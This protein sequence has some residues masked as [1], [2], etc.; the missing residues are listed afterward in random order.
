MKIDFQHRQSAHCENGVTANLLSFYGIHLSEPMIFGIGSGYFFS[1]MPFIKLHGMPV[2]SFRVLPGW[3]FKRVTRRLGIQV[4]RYKFSDPDNAMKELNRLL[5]KGIPVGMLVGV[6]QLPYFPKEYRFHFNA[7]NLTAFGRENGTYLISD[8]IMENTETLTVE[9]LK[10]VRFAKGTYPPNGRMYHITNV[11]GQVDI[12]S[13]II[14]GIKKT[15]KDM[16]TIPI[17]MFGIKG[18]RYL[19]KRIRMWPQKYG[20]KQAAHNLGQ[21]VRMLEEIG[22]GGAGFRFIYAA[23]L[24]ESAEILGK[25]WL[26]NVSAEMTAV[27]DLWREFAVLAARC[28]KNRDKGL[29]SYDSLADMLNNIADKEEHVFVQLRNINI[30]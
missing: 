21:V 3:I 30:K 8:P 17:P 4:K 20:E 16:L 22:T 1:H 19:G 5:E 6:Y 14:Q 9:E 24:Q 12:K 2:T 10:T 23:F 13:A 29:T 25:P 11:P 18:I 7:H 27:G 28:F 15:A 26:N